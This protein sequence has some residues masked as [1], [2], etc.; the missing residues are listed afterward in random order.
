[1]GIRVL[2][3]SGKELA[4]G[5]N[6]EQLMDKLGKRLKTVALESSASDEWNRH[7]IQRW[8]FGEMPEWMQISH[9]GTTMRAYPALQSNGE[10][11]DQVLVETAEKAQAV[12]RAGLVTLLMNELGSNVKYM[13]KEFLKLRDANLVYQRLA[14]ESVLVD[15]F[16]LLAVEDVFLSDG[17]PLPRTHGEFEALLEK[18]KGQFVARASELAKTVSAAL[19]EFQAVRMALA[20]QPENAATQDVEAQ[21]AGL[22]FPGFLRSAGSEQLTQYPRYLKAAARR[23]EKLE[24]GLA[25]DQQRAIEL[26]P[27]LDRVSMLSKSLG[28][29]KVAKA[30]WMLEELR[31]SLFAQ[32]LGTSGPISAK[33]IEKVLDSIANA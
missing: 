3:E 33:R 23:V 25:K 16:L 6:P 9:G 10:R 4:H 27:L 18:G 15:D 7:S 31:V 32:E 30:R 20:G 8:D 12:T 17:K 11:V 22:V 2:D 1:M 13:R 26:K 28:P 24:H 5:L 19:I 14:P 21:L 29:E